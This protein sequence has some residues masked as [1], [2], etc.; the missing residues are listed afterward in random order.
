MCPRRIHRLLASGWGWGLI[1]AHFMVR[2]LH[3]AGAYVLSTKSNGTV[4]QLDTTKAA[5]MPGFVDFISAESLGEEGNTLPVHVGIDGQVTTH[6][7]TVP[8]HAL[9]GNLSGMTLLFLV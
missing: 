4:T 1:C 9:Y 3:G 7:N 5:S 8:P 6:A 2:L